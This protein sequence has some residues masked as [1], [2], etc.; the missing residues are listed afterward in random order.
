MASAVLIYDG[1]CPFCSRYTRYL[2]LKQTVGGIQLIDARGGGPEVAQAI[3]K[4]F[5]LDEG[6][7]LV[8]DGAY[9]H[10]D[11]CLNRLA[12]MSSR[13]DLFNRVNFALF[14]SPFVSRVSYPVLR[15]GRNLVLKLLGRPKLG[16]R[17]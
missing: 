5:D 7:V 2:R 13:S 1:N 12:L 9:Y 17:P 3:A 14:R 6:M 11:A 16:E 10:G 8:M 4:G 15:F